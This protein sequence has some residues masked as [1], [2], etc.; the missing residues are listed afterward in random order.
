MS[1]DI[2]QCKICQKEF[3][4][5]QSLNSHMNIHS[6]TIRKSHKRKECPTCNIEI[7][8]YYFEKHLEKRRKCLKC[9]RLFCSY[10]SKQIF[11]SQS[12]SSF[13]NNKLNPPRTEESREK[14]RQ[15]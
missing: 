12:C 11:C 3:K 9:N 1:N 6:D 8:Y 5:S 14:I 15:K 7:V 2:Y 4:S 10:N 13:Y